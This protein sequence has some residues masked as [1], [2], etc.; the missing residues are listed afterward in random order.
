M[1]FNM[2]R[3][4][5]QADQEIKERVLDQTREDIKGAMREGLRFLAG[6]SP[7][8]TGQYQLNHSILVNT[9]DVDVRGEPSDRNRKEGL[10]EL[11][12]APEAVVLREE[13][14]LQSFELGDEI[15]LANPTFQASIVEDRYAM[16]DR[17][18][19][20]VRRELKKAGA[21]RRRAVKR[22]SKIK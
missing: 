14:N 7:I 20:I 17:A 9:E 5:K 18:L 1:P 15:H 12:I 3:F 8:W 21:K 6:N 10:G 22:L 19:D 11:A 2:Q 4:L 13:A 16:Y